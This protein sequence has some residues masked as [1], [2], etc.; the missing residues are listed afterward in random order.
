[1]E[2]GTVGYTVF[3]HIVVDT[4]IYWVATTMKYYCGTKQV[5]FLIV[6]HH[7]SN[8]TIHAIVIHV[9]MNDSCIHEW[10]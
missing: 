5:I 4:Q 3:T 9:Y 10:Q 1:M 7:P 6:A 2:N 8:S